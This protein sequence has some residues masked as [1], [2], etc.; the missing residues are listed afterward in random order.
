MIYVCY[1][2]PKDIPVIIY[3]LTLEG[4]NMFFNS[5]VVNDLDEFKKKSDV[6]VANSS[7]AALYDT[8]DKIYT[9]DLYSE[10]IS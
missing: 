3:Q 1:C 7:D 4:S 8:K 5:A 6:I 10:I 9:R 2:L